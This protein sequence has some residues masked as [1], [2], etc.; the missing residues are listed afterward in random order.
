MA[1][2]E[3]QHLQDVIVNRPFGSSNRRNRKNSPQLCRQPQ[4]GTMGCSCAAQ[5]AAFSPVDSTA[6]VFVHGPRTRVCRSSE[7][8]LV[9]QPLWSHLMYIS[10]LVSCAREER[11][12]LIH[13]GGSGSGEPCSPVSCNRRRIQ[14]GSCCY[15]CLTVPSCLVEVRRAS[16]VHTDEWM[17][18]G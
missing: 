16:W 18:G 8:W 12:R 2:P 4:G 9:G 14:L 3:A 6:G 13:A 10:S 15:P 11:G 17:D 5:T 1:A 7:V